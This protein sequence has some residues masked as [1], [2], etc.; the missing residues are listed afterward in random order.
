MTPLLNQY[1]FVILSIALVIGAGV[2]LLARRP[3]WNDYLAFGAIL[4]GLIAAWIILH[5]RQTPLMEDARA[6]VS[7]R[8][9]A[10]SAA[11]R[12]VEPSGDGRHHDGLLHGVVGLAH[13]VDQPHGQLGGIAQLPQGA[14]GFELGVVAGEASGW[15]FLQQPLREVL[16]RAVGVPVRLDGRFY[17]RLLW[18]PRLQIEHL[19][20]GAAP[21]VPASHLVD[22]RRVALTWHWGDVWRWHRGDALTLRSLGADRLDVQLVRLA[23]GR[24]TIPHLPSGRAAL[25][26][27][28]ADSNR[29]GAFLYAH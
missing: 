2:I 4:A 12:G 24:G 7:R 15:P 1:S 17:L 21:D 25:V 19:T 5:P 29:G 26:A 27:S 10:G 22:G 11:G 3:R 23:D 18:H 6:V 8:N 9:S 13:V 16:Q 20:L 14:E 28:L